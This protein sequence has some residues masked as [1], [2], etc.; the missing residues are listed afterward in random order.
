L[1][2]V[3]VVPWKRQHP[4][5]APLAGSCVPHRVWQAAAVAAVGVATVVPPQP[6]PVAAAHVSRALK[7]AVT[8]E[9]AAVDGVQ[10]V[11]PVQPPDQLANVEPVSAWEARAT[12]PLPGA[13]SPE[14]IVV[15]HVRP[16]G[17]EE[18]VPV[19]VPARVTMTACLPAAQLPPAEPEA[20]P[21]NAALR[22]TQSPLLSSNQHPLGIAAA[23]MAVSHWVRQ[24]DAPN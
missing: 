4:D 7:V 8:A 10:V 12:V 18:T 22:H 5:N 19:P 17:V 20:L 13:K 3:Q 23:A 14:Q 11:L 15:P 24:V 2:Q 6:V 9:S 21:F 16:A 1:V